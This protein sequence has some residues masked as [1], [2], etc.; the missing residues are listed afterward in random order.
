MDLRVGWHPVLGDMVGGRRVTI[1]VD[2]KPIPALE[3]EPI[4]ASL[5][6]AGIRTTRMSFHAGEPRGPFCMIG[7][8]TECSMIVDGESNVKTCITPVCDGMRVETTKGGKS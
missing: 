1:Y 6:A 7:Q 3:G 8:C 5:Y 2:G 4:A